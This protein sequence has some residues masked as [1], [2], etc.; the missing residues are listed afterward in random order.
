MG[1]RA[2]W[3]GLV[4]ATGSALT[5]EAGWGEAL[6]GEAGH[7]FGPVPRGAIVRHQFVLTN[8]LKEAVSI[9]DVR[10]SCGCTTGRALATTVPPGKAAVVEAE[11]DT[12]N[13]VGRKV[14]TLT[15]SLLTASGKDD[16]V[17]LGV[18]STILSDIVLNPGSIDL[19]TV[20]KGQ[21]PSAVLTIERLGAPNWR[22]ERMI[23]TSRVLRA[24]LVET[25][26]SVS[27]VGYRL[28]VTL[29]PGA[30]AGP[31]RDEIRI[32]TNDPESPTIPVLVTGQ[33]RG[34][35][36][37][38]PS[39]LALGE[40]SSASVVSGRYL[41]RASKP[42][43]I[44]SFEG[45][46][47]GFKLAEADAG[48]KALHVVTLTYTPTPTSP[49]GDLHRR[50]RVHTDLAGEPPVELTATLRVP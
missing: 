18:S 23:S 43:A 48:S 8:S 11:M 46:G 37:A 4:L 19:G 20:A 40:V 27:G 41:V 26:R 39:V 21:T 5:A 1:G 12:R 49:R 15:I 22:A 50:F 7:D 16:E 32:V 38:T 10:A 14:T 35:L 6:F 47:D 25:D 44:T 24:E 9:I 34:E 28:T 31:I 29:K 42:F 13:F 2:V 33:V 30:P 36:T 45:A 17:R 3:L